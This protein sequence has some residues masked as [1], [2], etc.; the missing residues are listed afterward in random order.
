[1]GNNLQKDA[2]YLYEIIRW[3]GK[4]RNHIVLLAL[5]LLLKKLNASHFPTYDH[6][7]GQKYMDNISDNLQSIISHLDVQEIV[8]REL[9]D[10][11]FNIS[12]FD[13]E[14]SY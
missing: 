3:N 7:F 12:S 14:Y 13:R 11:V 4:I 10:I 1:M 6:H 2:K 8:K 9:L 5:F